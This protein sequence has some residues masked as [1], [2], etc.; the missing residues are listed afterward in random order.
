MH[1][2]EG[3]LHLVDLGQ[4]L[5]V[6]L[7]EVGQMALALLNHSAACCIGSFIDFR[8][9]RSLESLQW[10]RNSVP[11]NNAMQLIHKVDV[12]LIDGWTLFLGVAAVVHADLLVR[13]VQ[14]PGFTLVL[15]VEVD[16][17]EWILEVDEEV[18]HV[19]H[20][21]R[22][23]LVFDYVKSG[24]TSL[25]VP[26]NLVLE[27]FLGISTRDVFHAKVGSQIRALLN[28]VNPDWFVIAS[29]VGSL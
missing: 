6:L 23:F 16:D 18:A 3:L 14:L 24:I 27:F 11:L 17:E 22:L 29:L 8:L 9:S 13:V 15:V 25:V 4:E 2:A 5:L 20:L 12:Q 28:Q 1:L 21:L 26:I 19:R 7:R 10:S